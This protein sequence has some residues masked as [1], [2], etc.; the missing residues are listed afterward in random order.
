MIAGLG[1]LTPKLEV[2]NFWY[3][4]ITHNGESPFIPDGGK[5]KVFRNVV[6]DYGADPSGNKDS[7]SAFQKAINGKPTNPAITQNDVDKLK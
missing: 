7:S 1:P 5:W 2:S 6:A 4:Q 3:E